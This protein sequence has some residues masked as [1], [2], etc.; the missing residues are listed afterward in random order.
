MIH[1]FSAR[2]AY[3]FR[4][5][6]IHSEPRF[7]QHAVLVR[8][9][10]FFLLIISLPSEWRIIL[11]HCPGRSLPLSLS[12][13]NFSSSIMHKVMPQKVICYYKVCVYRHKKSRGGNTHQTHPPPPPPHLLSACLGKTVRK[14]T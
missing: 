5:C 12:S 10:P 9:V 7:F 2:R 3:V 14:N 4:V 13:I 1:N 8:G 6:H 11:L